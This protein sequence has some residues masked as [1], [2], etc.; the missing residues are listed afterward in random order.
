MKGYA[1]RAGRVAG[2][3]GGLL[4]AAKLALAATT[5][6]AA[7]SRPC[8]MSASARFPGS[9]H[10]RADHAQRAGHRRRPASHCRPVPGRGAFPARRPRNCTSIWANSPWGWCRA[11]AW[12][13]DTEG[14]TVATLLRAPEKTAGINA[15]YHPVFQMLR[16]RGDLGLVLEYATFSR[17]DGTWIMPMARRLERA[18]GSF[19]GT[20]GGRGKIDYFQDFYRDIALEPGTS[21]TLMHR[22]GTLM[23]PLSGSGG[24]LGK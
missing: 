1:G 10:R 20:I 11:P 13:F 16:A 19:A 3:A 17:L 23:G 12:S 7:T 8:S 5:P 9:G 2:W 18:D 6:S 22:K 21:V 14:N 4:I 24:S 15:S